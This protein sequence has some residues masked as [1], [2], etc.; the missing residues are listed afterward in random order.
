MIELDRLDP[1]RTV[2]AESAFIAKNATILGDVQVDSEASV[3]YG[4]VARGDIEAI[5]IGAGSNVQ[6]LSVLHADPSYACHIGKGV[7]VGHRCIVHGAT[8]E[9]FALIGMGAILMNGCIIGSESIVGAGALVTEG[10]V[11]PPRSLV[12]GAPAKVKR[13]VTD[14]EVE[15]IRESAQRYIANALRHKQL[16]A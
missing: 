4:V 13:Q 11:I 2:I 3:W 12:L 10:T 14:E 5:R 16:L 15:H 9:D 8:V 6:D 1:A 7:T